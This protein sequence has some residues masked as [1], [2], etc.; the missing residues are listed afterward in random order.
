LRR[1]NS[2]A[3]IEVEAET[4]A[5]AKAAADKVEGV[6]NHDDTLIDSVARR[7]SE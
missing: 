1:T 5:A 2:A 4:A 7:V 3:E 6:R